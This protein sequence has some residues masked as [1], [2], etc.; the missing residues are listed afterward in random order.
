MREHY[1]AVG[2]I[3]EETGETYTKETAGWEEG[4]NP[5]LTP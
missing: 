2:D 4:Y 3:N 1:H 5:G